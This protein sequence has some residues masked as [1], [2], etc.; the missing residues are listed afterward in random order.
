MTPRR[1]S[2][3]P[4]PLSRFELSA[5]LRRERK[6]VGERVASIEVSLRSLGRRVDRAA[7]KAVSF[8]TSS[9]IGS[10]VQV[11]QSDPGTEQAFDFLDLVD[12]SLKDL[13]REAP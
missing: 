2:A 7:E 10:V 8:P 5:Q 1:R 3:N 6:Q 12:R 11:P 4:K 9:V 13:L